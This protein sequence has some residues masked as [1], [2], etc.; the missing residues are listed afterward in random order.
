[1]FTINEVDGKYT[2]VKSSE[3][4]TTMGNGNDL[5]IDKVIIFIN[6]VIDQLV[7]NLDINVR[8]NVDITTITYMLFSSIYAIDGNGNITIAIK[9]WEGVNSNV[10][11][12]IS[13]FKVVMEQQNLLPTTSTQQVVVKPPVAVADNTNNSEN[14][15]EKEVAEKEKNDIDWW[16]IAKPVLMI[17]GGLA[18]GFLVGR[19]TAPKESSSIPS[20][21]TS[22]FIDTSSFDF[23]GFNSCL[24]GFDLF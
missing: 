16:E 15:K 14:K 13:T 23:S 1:M 11:T 2:V 12:A 6:K 18:A 22:A 5:V 21:G 8:T 17:G 9:V 10:E 3:D 4:F 20:C 24:G 7:N 19:L